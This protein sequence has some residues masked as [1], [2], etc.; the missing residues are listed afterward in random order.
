MGTI[1][2][3]LQKARDTRSKGAD[4]SVQQG[5]YYGIVPRG[6]KG[7]MT[8]DRKELNIDYSR[9]K[10]E[11]VEPSIYKR[12]KILAHFQD[13]AIADHIKIIR[14]QILNSL[15]KIGGNSLLVTSA[16][17]SEGKTFT[18]I[19]LG[20]S[21]AQELERTVLLID[22]DLRIPANSHRDF[23]K[24]F[25]E[26]GINQGLSDY[27]LGHAEIPDILINPGI[28]K[29]T[30]LPGGKPSPNAA[31]LLGSAR[32]ESLVTEIKNRY[33]GDRIVI[34][35]SSSL[36]GTAE[37]LALSRFVD[38]ILL[39]VQA[40]RTQPKELK[41]VKELLKDQ[42]ILGTILNKYRE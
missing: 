1:M 11:K 26:V 24:D 22:A 3:S 18:S 37:P 9:T 15:K 6:L 27:L 16:N 36:I 13:S 21:I 28:Q 8:D 35:D 30:I 4:H 23:A 14:N 32:M 31:E 38:G 10:I 29:L 17:P 19:N 7:K 25:F 40:E 41:R 5:E 42:P 2:K 33:R 12:N 34:F 20:V 39:V